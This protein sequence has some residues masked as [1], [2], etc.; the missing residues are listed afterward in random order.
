MQENDGLRLPVARQWFSGERATTEK[1]AAEA[2]SNVAGRRN[3]SGRFG[4]Y[5]KI[6]F[7]LE[8]VGVPICLLL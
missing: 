1:I 2:F 7:E 4:D 3:I 8:T 6:Q 5:L